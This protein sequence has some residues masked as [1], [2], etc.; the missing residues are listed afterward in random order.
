MPHRN[1]ISDSSRWDRFRF[2]DGDIVISTPPKCGTTWTQT[3]CAYLVFGTTDLPAPVSQLSPWLDMLTNPLEE[4][5]TRLEAQDHRRFVKTHTPLSDLPF[6]ER[7][8]YVSV[9]RDPRD[10]SLSWEHHLANIDLDALFAARAAAEGLDDLADLAMPEAPPA[11]PIERFWVWADAE[12]GPMQGITLRAILEHLGEFWARRDE[13]NIVLLHY[14]DLQSDLP[15]EIRRLA[16]ALG[17]DVTDAQVDAYAAAAGFEHM[18]A[19]AERFAPDVANGIWQSTTAFFHR[20][21]S[22]QWR[23]LL[24]E[25]S[26]RRYEK[27]V[28]ELVPADFAA[29]AH[30][31]RSGLQ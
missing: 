19:D 29:W 17:I 9:G 26:L 12:E 24:D 16:G 30:H 28:A 31:G 8:T 5:L 1:L 22:G 6:D 27:R 18:R 21:T 13:R 3:L 15:G 2:R 4:V 10:V 20:G 11:D 7:V 25:L 23:D 14:A